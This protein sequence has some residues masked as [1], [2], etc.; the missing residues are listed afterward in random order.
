[1]PSKIPIQ[2]IDEEQRT[3]AD[4]HAS[5]AFVAPAQSSATSYPVVEEENDSLGSGWTTAGDTSF[6]EEVIVAPADDDSFA[7]LALVV[8]AP[9]NNHDGE[10][11]DIPVYEIDGETFDKEMVAAAVVESSEPAESFDMRAIAVRLERTEVELAIADA[12]RQDLVERLARV[13]ADFDNF[14]KRTERDKERLFQSVICDVVRSLLPV[15]D[16]MQRAVEAEASVQANESE[17]FRRFL[18]G[19][20]LIHRQLRDVLETLGIKPVKT[21]GVRFD[22]HVHEAAATEYSAEHE[23]ETVLHEMM[24]GYHLGDVLLRPAMVKVST[25]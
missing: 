25:R 18:H 3:A 12:D 2:F 13:Q 11:E 16:N 20:E 22:P 1:M 17:E 24:K 15:L 6:D 5:S 14:R 23:P 9:E 8:D 10:A 19:V 4:E 21:V 7:D